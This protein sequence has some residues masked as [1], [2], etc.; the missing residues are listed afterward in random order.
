MPELAAAFIGL[1]TL[2]GSTAVVTLTDR[3]A[4]AM[5]E[6]DDLMP[7]VAAG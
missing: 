6:E 1:G 5:R 7:D 2:P 3:V 4:D